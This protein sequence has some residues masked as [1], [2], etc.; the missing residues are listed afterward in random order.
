VDLGRQDWG[1]LEGVDL[2]RLEV[3]AAALG[4]H[5]QAAQQV[6]VLPSMESRNQ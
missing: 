3:Q 4:D 5:G 1:Y 2:L 6:G